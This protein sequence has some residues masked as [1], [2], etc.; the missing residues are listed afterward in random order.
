MKFDKLSV[1]PS[2]KEII[3]FW[4]KLPPEIFPNLRNF[5]QKYT[6]VALQVRTFVNEHFRR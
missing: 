2:G 4:R 3:Q 1:G 6:Y 5:A